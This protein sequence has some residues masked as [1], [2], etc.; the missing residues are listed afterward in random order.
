MGEGAFG[1]EPFSSEV[2]LWFE[3]DRQK[4]SLAEVGPSFVVPSEPHSLPPC[5]GR[6]VVS[7][8]GQVFTRN[9]HLPAGMSS[10]QTETLVLAD[11][12]TAPF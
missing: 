3:N 12:A 8:D 5:H 10:D 2:E 6:V 4:I 11:D 7:I 1:V 9:V